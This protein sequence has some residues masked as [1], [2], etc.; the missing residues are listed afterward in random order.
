MPGRRSVPSQVPAAATAP[1]QRVEQEDRTRDRVL[2]GILADGPVTA[3]TLGVTLGLTAAAVR[4]HLGSLTAD[5]LVEVK[6]LPTAARRGRGRP[7]RHYVVTTAGH[8]QLGT[9]Y[10][11]LALAAL[12]YLVGSAGPGA[13]AE[14]AGRRAD[15]LAERLAP[16]VDEA[17]TRLE[18]RTHALAEGLDREGYAASSAELG[19][20]PVPGAQLCQ[21]HCPI[22]DVAARYPEFCE[23]ESRAFSRLLGTEVR[24]LATLAQGAHVCTTH[25]SETH[26][27]DPTDRVG[28]AV[29]SARSREKDR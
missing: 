11:D 24:R 26:P 14:F 17:G 28:S 2:R 3:S 21:G 6:Q 25:V 4:R 7:A 10:A 23:A 8:D 13:V 18:A 29:S 19:D 20:T 16:R 15:A 12:D 9:G 27:M 5:G 1:D 22:Q